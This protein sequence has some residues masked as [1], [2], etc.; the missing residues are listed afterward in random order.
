MQSTLASLEVQYNVF[1]KTHSGK[2]PLNAM[3]DVKYIEADKIASVDKFLYIP[4]DI[5]G[6]K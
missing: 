4:A 2:V 3:T 1:M 6:S 5:K